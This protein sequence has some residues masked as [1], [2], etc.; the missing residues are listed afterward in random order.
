MTGGENSGRALI[1]DTSSSDG[2]GYL[3]VR[4]GRNF[5][6]VDMYRTADLDLDFGVDAECGVQCAAAVVVAEEN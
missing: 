5:Q 6:T 4:A 2:L 3:L 1:R